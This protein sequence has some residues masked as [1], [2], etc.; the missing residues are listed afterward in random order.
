MRALSVASGIHM[1]RLPKAVFKA[2]STPNRYTTN[3]LYS[4]Y[5]RYL[6]L[7]YLE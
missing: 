5:P 3:L 4:F 6:D 2:E 1:P 7:A